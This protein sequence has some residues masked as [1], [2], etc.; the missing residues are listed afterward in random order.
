LFRVVSF[1]SRKAAPKAKKAKAKV[2]VIAL[3]SPHRDDEIGEMSSTESSSSDQSD[4]S[5]SD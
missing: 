4:S 3:P 2:K 1:A 5:H